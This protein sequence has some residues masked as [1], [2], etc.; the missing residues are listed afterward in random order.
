MTVPWP[1]PISLMTTAAAAAAAAV[2]V[3]GP[4]RAQSQAPADGVYPWGA[5][6][7][8]SVV[9]VVEPT[10]PADGFRARI[11]GVVEVEAVVLKDGRVGEARVTRS[12]DRGIDAAA[13]QAVRRWQFRPA[14]VDGQPVA[15]RVPVEVEFRL[16][17]GGET[18]VPSALLDS[19]PVLAQPVYASN[20]SAAPVL[21]SQVP[22]SYTAD[23]IRARIQG[24]V[25]LEAVVLPDGTVGEVRVTRSLDDRFGLDEKA[26]E[27]VRQWRFA[28]GRVDGQPAAVAVT[29]SLDFRLPDADGS[30]NGRRSVGQSGLKGRRDTAP[31]AGDEEFMQG[32]VRVGEEGV[33]GPKLIDAALPEYTAQARAAGLEG[34]VVVQ[35]VVLPDGTVGRARVIESLS[36]PLGLDAEALRAALKYEFEP[37]SG[38]RNGEPAAVVVRIEILFTLK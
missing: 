21:A 17:A 20:V 1:I 31:P 15:M 16:P 37:G 4:A 13:L 24:Q 23:A 28:P 35:A 30:M 8:P 27:A 6:A 10:Y 3:P 38:T 9:R 7:P 29:V 26:V 32:A 34:T 22:P 36:A 25:Q 2:L 11:Q 19:P 18:A 14:T 33:S 5:G 12:L